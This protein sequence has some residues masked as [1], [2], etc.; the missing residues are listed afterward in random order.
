MSFWN[1][2]VT[3]GEQVSKVTDAVIASGDALV[4]T[5]EEKAE[6]AAKKREL[7]WKFMEMSRNE[8]S[9]KSVTRRILAFMVF[10]HWFAFLDVSLALYLMGHEQQAKDVFAMATDMYWIVFSV[11]AFYFGAHLLGTHHKGKGQ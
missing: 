7:W 3:G 2:F 4:Y 10:L 11:A 9:I 6:V 8:T 1:W 5:E